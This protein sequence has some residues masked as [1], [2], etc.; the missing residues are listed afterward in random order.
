MRW[1]DVPVTME[2][3]HDTIAPGA[4]VPGRIMVMDAL[5]RRGVPPPG[6]RVDGAVD[7]WRG[8]DEA[9]VWLGVL[10]VELP[11]WWLLG[12]GGGEA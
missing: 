11:Q 4:R 2:H 6:F 7:D 12:P 9:I 3:N 1:T 10:D 5:R 8:L